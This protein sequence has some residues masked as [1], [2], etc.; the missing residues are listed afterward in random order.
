MKA[1]PCDLTH[2]ITLSASTTVRSSSGAA[3]HSS[4]TNPLLAPLPSASPDLEDGA[5]L[6]AASRLLYPNLRAR[7]SSRMAESPAETPTWMTRSGGG[8]SSSWSGRCSRGAR[9]STAAYST[10]RSEGERRI[11]RRGLRRRG[12]AEAACP[13]SGAGGPVRTSPFKGS[14]A[15]Q[16]GLCL[17]FLNGCSWQE[18]ARSETRWGRGEGDKER[19]RRRT[20]K[21][22]RWTR[23]GLSCASRLSIG[24]ISESKHRAREKS[25]SS[26][27]VAGSPP[28]RTLSTLGL[29]QITLKGQ[30]KTR[31]SYRTARLEAAA[32]KK[33][34]PL[35]SRS[36]RS[37]GQTHS[38][39]KP[40]QRPCSTVSTPGTLA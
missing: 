33:R 23:N 40:S 28:S 7:C 39:Q 1:T 31:L 13:D 32:R 29:A 30:Q 14:T 15:S 26:A 17:M 9:S 20:P 5:S 35:R 6:P 37:S 38:A 36:R 27:D 34:C 25:T 21:P 10:G 24:A 22:V 19:Q 12:E 3:S 2:R 4:A 8:V 16:L 18:S 11:G